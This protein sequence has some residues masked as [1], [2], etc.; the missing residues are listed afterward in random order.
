MG[1]GKTDQVPLPI[2]STVPELYSSMLTT[3]RGDLDTSAIFT[4]VEDL[5]N[6]KAL[7]FKFLQLL[8]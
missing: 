1:A 8:L 7:T 5:A 3:G 6:F 2:T 4:V